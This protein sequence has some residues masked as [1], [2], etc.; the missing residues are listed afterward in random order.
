MSDIYIENREFD[1]LAAEI[2]SGA[3]SLRFKAGGNSMHPFLQDG[4]ILEVR[5]ISF[6]QVQTGDI[7]LCR[8]V[9]GHLVAHRARQIDRQGRTLLLQGDY[10]AD[11][12]G[13]VRAQDVLGWVVSVQR[14]NRVISLNTPLNRFLSHAWGILAP[15]RRKLAVIFRRK[16]SR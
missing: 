14:G 10:L 5:P 6:D 1:S 8:L 13:D 16:R 15:W 9:D 2:L 12:D 3:N 4:D 7:V 11:P